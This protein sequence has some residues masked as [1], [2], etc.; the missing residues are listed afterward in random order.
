MKV[1][2]AIPDLPKL[3]N[4]AANMGEPTAFHGAFHKG[5]VAL[6]AQVATA[7]SAEDDMPGAAAPR[8]GGWRR[9]ALFH[10]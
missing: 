6:L 10:R 8:T 7:Q 9:L 2:I 3:L 5:I 1:D 4:R